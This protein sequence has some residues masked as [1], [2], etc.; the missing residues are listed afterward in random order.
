MSKILIIDD[1]ALILKMGG[2]LLNKLG[3]EA[4]KASSGE[5]GIELMKKE[6]PALVLLDVFMPG[7]SGVETLAAIKA[8]KE[9]ADVPVCFITGTPDDEI[10]EKSRELGAVYCIKKPLVKDEVHYVLSKAGI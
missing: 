5:E 9:L 7:L 8:N 2:F 4:V 6:K 1:D 3:Y 10:I